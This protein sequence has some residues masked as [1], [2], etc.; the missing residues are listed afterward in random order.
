MKHLSLKITAVFCAL[1]LWFFVVSSR[2]YSL[3][4][5]VPL[6]LINLPENLALSNQIPEFVEV[7]IRGSGKNLLFWKQNPGKL[8][9]NLRHLELGAQRINLDLQNFIPALSNIKAERILNPTSLNIDLDTRIYRKVPIKNNIIAEAATGFVIVTD[10]VLHPPELEVSGSR[11]SIT[12]IFELPTEALKITN[13]KKD[14]LFQIKREPL[15][16]PLLSLREEPITLSIKVQAL[17]TLTLQQIPVR[18]IG[19]YD[20]DRFF[21]DP[22]S[23]SITLSGG[24]AIIDSIKPEDINLFIEFSRFSI[25]AK[26]SLGPTLSLLHPHKSYTLNPPRFSLR[27]QPGDSL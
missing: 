5:Q 21:L 27:E 17:K 23:T 14:T 12:K 6:H 24:A 20:R 4:V 3:D 9:L 2:D 18:L 7:R 11:K 15:N 22:S 19:A 26:S 8:E 1:A 10:P 25:E 13:L 16:T